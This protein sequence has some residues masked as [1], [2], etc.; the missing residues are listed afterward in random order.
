[1]SAEALPGYMESRSLQ[2]RL[3]DRMAAHLV[4]REGAM[5]HDSC[6]RFP[7]PRDFISRSSLETISSL[8]KGGTT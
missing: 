7:P 8:T 3:A 6:Q 4:T 1:M 5:T 2:C